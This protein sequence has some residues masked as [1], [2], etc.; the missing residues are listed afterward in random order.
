MARGA[1][2][3]PR[4]VSSIRG[5]AGVSARVTAWHRRDQSCTIPGRRGAQRS[6]ARGFN[7]HHLH[8]FNRLQL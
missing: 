8:Q 3:G 7:S 6:G 4:A 5:L 1:V 2:R